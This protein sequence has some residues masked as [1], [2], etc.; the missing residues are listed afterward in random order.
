MYTN[1]PVFFV[2]I[3]NWEQNSNLF[4]I[5]TQPNQEHKE[6]AK[7][8][9]VYSKEQGGLQQRTGWFTAKNRVVYSKEQC[10]LLFT[11]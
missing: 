8:R 2:P 10:W 1:N 11:W 4:F 9:V 3:L 7:N 5:L 6:T